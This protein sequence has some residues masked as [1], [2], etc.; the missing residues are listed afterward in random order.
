MDG[1]CQLR[2]Q[3][4]IPSFGILRGKNGLASLQARS[5]GIDDGLARLTQQA[6]VF[7]AFQKGRMGEPKRHR[8]NFVE[9]DLGHATAFRADAP[10]RDNPVSQT[11]LDQTGDVAPSQTAIGE[12]HTQ[13]I[14]STRAAG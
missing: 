2:N 14:G 5:R 10:F 1:T 12:L 6:Q 13:H 3:A 8:P 11:C 7:V 4:P 9:H